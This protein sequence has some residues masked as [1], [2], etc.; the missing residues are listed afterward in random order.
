MS[1]SKWPPRLDN[2][3]SQTVGSS[4]MRVRTVVLEIIFPQKC[5][6]FVGSVKKRRGADVE[7]VRNKFM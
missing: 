4:N 5:G 7:K 1:K 2:P 3:R 6:V